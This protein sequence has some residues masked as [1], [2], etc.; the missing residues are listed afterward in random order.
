MPPK[1][2][3]ELPLVGTIIYRDDAAGVQ[4]LGEVF[5]MFLLGEMVPLT[6][7]GDSVITPAQS[8]PVTWLSEAFKTLVLNV[9]LTG[10]VIFVFSLPS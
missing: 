8:T 10:F 7:T 2:T 5:S 1:S 4:S 9:T 6:V 3:T